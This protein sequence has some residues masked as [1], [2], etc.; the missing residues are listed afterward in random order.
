[1]VQVKRKYANSSFVPVT[2][3]N[4]R[5]GFSHLTSLHEL[6]IV[7]AL[8]PQIK[9]LRL[10]VRDWLRFTGAIQPKSPWVVRPVWLEEVP[11]SSS[12][13][14]TLMRPKHSKGAQR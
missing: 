1:M 9:K 11:Y 10:S 13:Y 14:T 8:A 12:L 5:Y 4:S 3:L 7:A 6:G 2:V